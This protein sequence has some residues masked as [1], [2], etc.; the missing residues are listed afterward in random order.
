MLPY[1]DDNT[2]NGAYIT[3]IE[4]VMRVGT[5]D[6]DGGITII[7]DVLLVGDAISQCLIDQIGAERFESIEGDVMK[8]LDTIRDD[9][10]KTATSVSSEVLKALEVDDYLYKIRA[11]A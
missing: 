1:L 3:I 10:F 9:I 11:M 2:G 8:G 7:D 6:S 5:N 4:D